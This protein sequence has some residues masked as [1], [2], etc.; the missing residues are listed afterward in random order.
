MWYALNGNLVSTFINRLDP[1]FWGA[2]HGPC[3]NAEKMQAGLAA[4]AT[5]K[6]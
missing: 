3:T 4:A 6:A 2:A 5:A 1:S